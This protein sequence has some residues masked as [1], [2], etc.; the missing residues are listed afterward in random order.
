MPRASRKYIEV[1]DEYERVL[2]DNYCAGVNKMAQNVKVYPAE[3]YFT[4]TS[5]EE[6]KPQD[7][8][9]LFIFMM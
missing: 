8:A 5:F 6:Y 2:L 4:M 7:A 9:S 1:M 3:F